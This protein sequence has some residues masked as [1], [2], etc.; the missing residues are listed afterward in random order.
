[1]SKFYLGEG[2]CNGRKFCWEFFTQLFVH[3]SG[4]IRLSTLIWVLLE[5]SFPPEE[6]EYRWCQF[7]SKVMTLEVESQGSSRPAQE[8]IFRIANLKNNVIYILVK[9]SCSNCI[10]TSDIEFVSAVYIYFFSVMI[11]SLCWTLCFK[12]SLDVRQWI[13]LVSPGKPLFPHSS[14]KFPQ[15]I[16]SS[17]ILL[18]S[19]ANFRPPPP[20]FPKL[21][22]RPWQIWSRAPKKMAWA[23]N[24][25]SFACVIN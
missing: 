3:I 10:D 23:P 8:S 14:P 13:L 7:W 11:W 25:W 16:S 20:V 12:N 22:N 6:V 4:A 2:T 18:C 21:P 9:E 15:F 5:R 17:E 1:M 19:Q 24:F